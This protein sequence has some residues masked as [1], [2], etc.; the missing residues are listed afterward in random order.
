MFFAGARNDI[1]KGCLQLFFACATFF[2]YITVFRRGISP[3][4][5]GNSGMHITSPAGRF[6]DEVEVSMESALRREAERLGV[7]LRDGGNLRDRFASLIEDIAAGAPDGKLV[8]LIDEYDKP[9]TRWVGESEVLPFQSFL[10]SFYSVVKL[11]ESKQRF[12]LMTGVSK[13]SKVSI[14]SDLNNLIDISMDLRFSTLLGYTHDEVRA[15]FPACLNALANV[16]GT[17]ENGA[18]T[19]VVD[20]YDGY[21]FDRSM[22][23]VFNPVSLG[24]ALE[25]S[26]MRSYWFETGTPGWL[27]SYAKKAPIDVDNLEV[28]EAD[29][30]TFEPADPYMPTV[31]FQ[32]GYLTIA[33]FEEIGRARVY[34]MKFPNH[35]VEDGFTQWLADPYCC[36]D[37][38]VTLLGIAFDC[39]T[40]NI[41]AWA[42]EKL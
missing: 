25:S 12:C 31:L 9:L 23:R 39:D 27:M 36:T 35:E 1:S 10:K 26:D 13:F 17:D 24:R 40:H 11:T 28:S 15:N 34:R 42:A 4:P 14:F 41:G 6:L 3:R 29:L 38:E 22:T 21:C 8:L 33:D 30:G 20:M 32:T 18:F 7:A 19:E 37:D 16:L 5:Q 2:A